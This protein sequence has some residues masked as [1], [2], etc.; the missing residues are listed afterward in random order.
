MR[1]LQFASKSFD[2]E[3]AD[4]CRGAAVP[5]EIQEAVSAILADVHVRG[6]EAVSY[7]AA[8]FDGAKLRARDFRVKPA[9][10][11]AA[12]KRLPAAERKALVAAH[13]NI[14]AFN[15][16]SLPKNWLGKNKHGAQVGEINHPIRRVGLY[17][18]GGEVP[19]VSTV[20]MTATLA[21]IAGCPE[22]AVFTPSNAQGKIAD[23]LLAALDLVGIEEVYRVGGVQAIGAAAFGTLTVPAVD[24]VFGPGNAY[25]CEAKRQV[26]G[27]VG[28]DSLP[29][30]SEVM[31][32]A[33]DT[34]RIDFAAADLL[35]QAEHGSGREK[36][37]LVATSGKLIHDI[38]AE[39]QAQLKLISRSEKTQRVLTQGLLAVE[40][41]TLS[42]AV[43]IAN[44]VAPEHLELLVK[45]S[46]H[47]ALLRDIT[48]AGAIMLG[49]YTPTALGDFTA[50]PSHVLPTA[51]A[52]RFFS[53]LRVAD[54]MRRTSV[55]RYDK[56]SVKKG[57]PVVSAFATMEKL[58]AH[59]R[60]VKIRTL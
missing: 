19:L 9:E 30:P 47:K 24:K 53:G 54:F 23:G 7:Y 40:V 38:L 39:V 58:D 13:E 52:G 57:E 5:K 10:I 59:G 21:K 6:D 33:D 1:V 37:Y 15:K 46:S 25:V 42:E 48:T 4:F 41:K 55:I 35:A 32:I 50:G 51:R 8:K 45:E 16:Q 60:S 18:P 36:I 49:N 34:A 11:A 56:N 26:F 27:T 22:I 28:V 12:A 14:V 44:Y 17:V 43:K 31:I 3:L 2:T 29:G 20:L